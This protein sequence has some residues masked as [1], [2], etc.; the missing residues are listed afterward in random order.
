MTKIE[1][2]CE[3]CK[4]EFSKS[5]REECCVGGHDCVRCIK[6]GQ[7]VSKIEKEG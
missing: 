5:E 7:W 1:K 3:S 2:K 4:H 6:C